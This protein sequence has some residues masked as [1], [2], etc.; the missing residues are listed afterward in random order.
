MGISCDSSEVGIGAFLFHHYPDESERP[1]ANVS[2]TLTDRQRRCSQ[3]HKEALAVVFPLKKF[4]QF[5]CGRH[6]ILITDHK[7]LL[8]LF[9]YGEETPPLAANCLARWALMLNQYDYSAELQKK[10]SQHGNA[11]SFSHLA[12]GSDHQFDG[13]EMGE[14]VDNICTVRTYTSR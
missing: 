8:A 9:G 14:D 6:F 13:K 10:N 5:L 12:K 4:H 7:P 1:I 11:N 3:I 2:K